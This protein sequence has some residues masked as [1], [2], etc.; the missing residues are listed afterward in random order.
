ME[1]FKTEIKSINSKFIFVDNDYQRTLR[2]NDVKKIVKDFNP[3]VVRKPRVSYRGGKYWVF[4]GQHTIAALKEMNDGKDLMIDCEVY[5]GM[6]KRDEAEL[7][8]NQDG[9]T[10]RITT[11]EYL[12]SFDIAG[13]SDVTDFRLLVQSE[14]FI[15]DFKNSWAGDGRLVCFKAAYGIY[16]QIG[17]PERL[18]EILQIIKGAWGMSADGLRGQ[19]VSGLNI[20]L[21]DNADSYDKKRMI[22]KLSH[23]SPIKIFRDGQAQQ[24]GGN[25]RFAVEIARIYNSGLKKGTRLIVKGMQV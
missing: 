17:G 7:F 12:N 3:N 6:T 18:R 11:G 2:P 21:R 24:K 9:H 14:G 23:V 1:K 8:G 15:C 13:N 25:K 10:R 16:E 22:D 4:N 20:V 19:I 5:Y